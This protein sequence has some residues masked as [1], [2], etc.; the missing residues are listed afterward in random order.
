MGAHLPAQHVMP[1][2]MSHEEHLRQLQKDEA[3]KHRGAAAMGF[4][5]DASE[6]HFL[7]QPA[8]GSIVVA[9]KN[10]DDATLIA[11]IRV[12]LRDIASAFREGRF[13]A[14]FS[15]HAEMPPGASTMAEHKGKISYRY[16]EQPDGAR[17]VIQTNDAAT[18]AA[19]HEFLRYQ[20]V[21]HK[22]GDPLTVQ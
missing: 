17:V 22:T 11:Q 8:G 6:H 9:S 18:L 3:L 20:I 19:I 5:Q 10:P 16:T 7:L 15:T 2:G 13:E 21:E 12:H 4:D 1:A 14:P